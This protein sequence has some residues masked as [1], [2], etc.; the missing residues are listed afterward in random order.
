M[1]HNLY[2]LIYFVLGFLTTIYLFWKYP[3]DIIIFRIDFYNTFIYFLYIIAVI[4]FFPLFVIYFI[5]WEKEK[6]GRI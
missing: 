3:E 5:N 1:V 4:L 6:D 2:F